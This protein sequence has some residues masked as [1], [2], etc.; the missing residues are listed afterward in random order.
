MSVLERVSGYAARRSRL[1]L[2]LWLALLVLALPFAA[3]AP[4]K[5]STGGFEVG[6]SE[7]HREAAFLQDVPGRGTQPFSIVI[8]AS[9]E[10][11]ARSRGAAVARRMVSLH[12]ELRLAGPP[13]SSRDGRTV[14]VTGLAT[15]DQA[16][17]L[18]LSAALKRE[19]QQT[20]GSTRQYVVGPSPTFESLKTRVESGVRRAEVLTLPL[21]AIVLLLIFGALVATAMPLLL[22]A[23]CVA[24]TLAGVYVVASATEMSVYA[25]SMVSMIGIGVAVDYSLFVLARYREEVAEGRSHDEAVSVAFSTSG[26]AVVFSGVTVILALASILIVPV[27]AIQSMALGAMMVTA[28]AIAAVATFLP[29]LLERL[30]RSVERGRI[31]GI[32]HNAPSRRWD[33]LIDL[34]M[35]RP[36]RSFC[37]AAVVLIALAAPV[38]VMRTAMTGLSQ[39][40]S[41][42]P[43]VQG[44][45]LLSREI[46]GPGRGLEGNLVAA[47]VPL[48]GARPLTLSEAKGVAAAVARVRHV[49]SATVTPAGHAYELQASIDVDPE[50]SYAIGTLVPEAR[51]AGHAAA[52]EVG[53]QLSIGGLTA[54]DRDVD[55]A[56]ANTFWAVVGLAVI[57]TFLVLMLLLRS[58]LLPL[59]AV[60]M[61]LLSIGASYGVLVAVFQWGWLTWA[62]VEAPGHVSTLSRPLIFAVTFGLSM[63][64]E[65]FL[66]S[67]IRERYDAHG[68][69]E[70]AVR[71]G[72]T[73][74][75]KL[76]TGAALIMVLVFSSFALIGVQSI[77]EI[78][79]GLAVAIAVDASITRLILVPATMR[80]LGEWN[81]WLPAWL[82]RLLPRVGGVSES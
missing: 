74:S 78:G 1:H 66:L 59:K 34:V 38:V 43:A 77:R 42:D 6:S 19:F 20:S 3:L 50:S 40:P 16:P 31:P 48:P 10:A 33:R 12:R 80:L 46:T 5:L 17:A 26:T 73:S 32:R 72:I 28:V 69:T 52:A 37:A 23:V 57:A 35:R 21:V 55:V 51:S 82:D 63:D 39:L 44:S 79:V 8:Q 67:R 64:Y 30:G 24:V 11:A 18:A 2:G 81:W 70:R 29:A 58:L 14:A 15:L 56:V 62:G 7:S 25:S 54:Y 65:V 60:I 47:L 9:T 71:E 41:S 75:A 22:G 53:A 61:N 27:R 45:R 36:G 4:G 68:D 13:Q 76:I 49:R